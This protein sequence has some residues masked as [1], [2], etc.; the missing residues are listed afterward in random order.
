TLPRASLRPRRLQSSECR[1]TSVNRLVCT[2]S[3]PVMP[4]RGPVSSP[5]NTL[6]MLAGMC[7]LVAVLYWAQ[8]VFIPL[9]LAILFSY[10]LMPVVSFLQRHRF[11]RVSA[12]VTVVLLALLLIGGIVS[13]LAVEVRQIA[14]DL[15]G[16]KKNIAQKLQYFRGGKTGV[17][18]RLGKMID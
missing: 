17:F 11:R 18:D 7:L 1:A 5:Q 15:P 4:R 12:V 14:E 8:T 13:L 2:W 3:D 10:A 6:A 16:Y 9:A